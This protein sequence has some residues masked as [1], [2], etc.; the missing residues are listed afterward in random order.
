MFLISHSRGVLHWELTMAN[1]MRTSALPPYLVRHYA[2]G[3]VG[4]LLLSLCSGG[5]GPVGAY[6]G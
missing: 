3:L 4:P 1:S 6:G 5:W 2:F